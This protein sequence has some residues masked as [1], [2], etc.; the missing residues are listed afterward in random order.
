MNKLVLLVDDDPIFNWVSTK[1]IGKVDPGLT[2]K[3]FVN[4]KD[5]LDFLRESYSGKIFYHILLDINMPGLNGWEFLDALEK[6]QTIESEN[7][8][9]YIVSSSTDDSDVKKSDGYGLVNGY[10][11]KPLSV[12]SIKSI[13]D[14]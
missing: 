12:E 7:L 3:S 8:S 2:I 14:L 5:A 13:L 9:I 6:M 10:F 11:N 1:M 4:G